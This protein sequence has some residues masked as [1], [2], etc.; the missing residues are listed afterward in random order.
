VTSYV[1]PIPLKPCPFCGSSE[2][3]VDD[4]GYLGGIQI[5]CSCGMCGPAYEAEGMSEDEEDLAAAAAWN[6]RTPS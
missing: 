4:G 2:L 1:L 5:Y 6:R 3:L